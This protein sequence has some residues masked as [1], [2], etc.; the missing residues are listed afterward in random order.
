MQ[1]KQKQKQKNVIKNKYSKKRPLQIFLYLFPSLVKLR[2]D[3][4]QILDAIV[5]LRRLN[6]KKK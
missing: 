3:Y 1:P 5:E 2:E 6:V 4:T